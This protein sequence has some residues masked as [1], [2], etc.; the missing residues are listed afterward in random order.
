MENV[1]VRPTLAKYGNS[2]DVIKG[3]CGFGLENVWLD[4]TG[5][6]K[7]T[8]KEWVLVSRITL[9]AGPYIDTYE[10]QTVSACS[11]ESDEC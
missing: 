8:R 10:C 11:T 1:Y 9:I 2:L 6:Y 4:K 5:A 3:E 7:T